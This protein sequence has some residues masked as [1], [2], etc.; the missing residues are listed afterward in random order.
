M[1][2]E[3]KIALDGIESSTRRLDPLETV[4]DGY[5][6]TELARASLDDITRIDEILAT[7]DDLSPLER[8][9]AY[10]AGV[11]ARL[12]YLYAK[13]GGMALP[14]PQFAQ[15]ANQFEKFMTEASA[16]ALKRY[17]RHPQD[18]WALQA[19][20]LDLRTL[21]AYRFAA[22]AQTTLRGTPDGERLSGFSKDIMRSVLH[23][24][25][26]LI[27]KMEK[28]SHGE[29]EVAQ[30]ARG[31]LYEML[32]LTYSRLKVIKGEGQLGTVLVRSALER[33]DRPWNGHAYPKRAFDIVIKSPDSLRLLQAKNHQNDDEYEWPIQKIE[34]RHFGLTL[35]NIPRHIMDLNLVLDD[36]VKEKDPL[37]QVPQLKAERRLDEVFGRQLSVRR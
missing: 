1:Q 19:K 16:Q 37:M 4:L 8:H 31:A 15:K 29:K 14:I 34:D 26:D 28:Q 5:D 21:A 27:V 18:Y 12:D 25:M 6:D 30:D 24:S 22:D 7:D 35:E 32:L 10:E 33:E 36:K 2:P 23:D 20:Y 9:K 11:D 13:N 3:N 17:D